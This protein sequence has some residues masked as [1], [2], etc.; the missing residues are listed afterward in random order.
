MGMPPMQRAAASA[1][2]D[3]SEETF[4]AEVL[5]RSRE[6]PVVIDFWAPWCGPCRT[7]GPTLEKL[8]HEAKG[9]FV[10]AKVNVDENPRLSQMFRVQGI[11][12][13]KAVKDGKIV[14]EFTGALPESRV[15]AW[16]KGFVAP[17]SNNLLEAAAALEATDPEEAAARYRVALAEDPN[18]AEIMFQL[19]RLLL[20]QRNPE[21]TALL[22]EIPSSSP[23]FARAQGALELSQFFAEAAQ[24][25]RAD[26]TAQLAGNPADLDARYQLAALD[27]S[28]GQYAE[29]MDGLLAL[30][31]RNR[32]FRDDG[33][34][35]TLIGLFALL[36]DDHPL[37]GEYRR[38][39]SG[40]LF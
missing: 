4:E 25:N 28:K 39:L 38:R 32:S 3:V 21:G 35:K 29:A 16:L 27:A 34:R 11:P 36:G 18:N 2:L 40:L 26:L 5:Q 9:A 23:L 1:V 14:D 6:V 30:V 20:L 24:A 7:L 13:V 31:A 12:A 17:P 37:V 10:L 19:G 15:R 22:G 33:A 8:A